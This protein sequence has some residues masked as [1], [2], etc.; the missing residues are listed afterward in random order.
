MAKGTNPAEV[1]E[2]YENAKYNFENQMAAF[3]LAKLN[4]KYTT[5][6]API[7]GIVSK[8]SIKAGNMLGNNEETFTITDFDPLLAVLHVPEH[9]LSKLK[10]GQTAMIKADAL[11]EKQFEGT[12]LRLSP[13]VD[14]NTGTFKVTVAVRDESYKL[15]PGMFGRIRILYD[16]HENTLQIPKSA[17]ISEDD[18]E[19]VFVVRDKQAFRKTIKTGYADGPMIEVVDGLQMD[20]QVV[21]I[22]HNSLQDSSLVEIVQ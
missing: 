19:H 9:E 16:V 12:I 5:I 3:E 7:D 1:A 11:P 15:K 13:T 22:G 8:R 4:V 17:V 6:R 20:D 2:T 18:N 21:T 14:S 10:V